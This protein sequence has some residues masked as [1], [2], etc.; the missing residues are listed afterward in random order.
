MAHA[1]TAVGRTCEHPFCAL[2]VAAP[3]ANA[4]ICINAGD[5][6]NCTGPTEVQVG[7]VRTFRL[8]TTLHTSEATQ[9]SSDH[10]NEADRLIEEADHE[11]GRPT[12]TMRHVC[13]KIA[14]RLDA[15]TVNATD[16][17]CVLRAAITRLDGNC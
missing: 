17:A 9:V 3:N 2:F 10:F 15:G 8:G 13:S 14:D 16:A 5:G 12:D 11:G 7:D 1:A 6:W 4:A